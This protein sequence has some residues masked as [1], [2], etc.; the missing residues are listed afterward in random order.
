VVVFVRA[1]ELV[2]IFLVFCKIGVL[3]FGGGYTMLPLLQK[4]I[5][6]ERGWTTPEEII[7]YYAISQS[8]PGIIAVN[9][10]MLIGY[11][12]GKLPGLAASA[13]GIACPSIVII[14]VIALFITNF[15][16][17]EIVTHAFNG[18]RVAVAVLIV[19][20]TVTMWKSG[21]KDK[22]CMVLFL[23]ALLVFTFAKVSPI[24]PVVAGA[25]A[26]IALKERG[27]NEKEAA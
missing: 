3:T 21:V 2:K 25:V 12:K 20:A 8:L 16:D 6:Q 18:I 5:V 19:N 4:D 11:R 26:G 13:L 9:T 14:L 15:L 17:L 22:I 1:E 23:A 27:K 10:S 24:L 7:D